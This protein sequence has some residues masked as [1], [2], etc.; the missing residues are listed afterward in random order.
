MLFCLYIIYI[1]IALPVYT[2]L[3]YCIYCT[4]T[5]RSL[6]GIGPDPPLQVQATR[7]T[8][9]G[10]ATSLFDSV[11][12][13][14]RSTSTSATV[15]QPDTVTLPVALL[16]I[17]ISSS[18]LLPLLR[19]CTLRVLYQCGTPPKQEILD[20]SMSIIVG[21]PYGRQPLV[22]RVVHVRVRAGV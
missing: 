9:A 10:L 20:G 17:L 7:G 21:H 5:V 22:V 12:H 1:T 6:P 16:V 15:A 11:F 19:L 3:V 2:V 14:T 8:D 4:I 18:F 13:L